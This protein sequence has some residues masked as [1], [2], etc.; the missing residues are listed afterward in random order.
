MSLN[1]EMKAA[2][3]HRQG[4][5]DE[6]RIETIALPQPGPGQILIRVESASVN[7]SDVKR[8]RGCPDP[9]IE[10]RSACPSFA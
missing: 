3:I 1:R 6:L 4:G 2:R 9:S 8:R 5:P 10:R 7:F